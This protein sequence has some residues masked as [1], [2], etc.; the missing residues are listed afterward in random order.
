MT[1]RLYLLIMLI[2]LPLSAMAEE[3][4]ITVSY[5]SS[6]YGLDPAH[7]FTT[8]EAQLFT[9]VYEGLVSYH[10]LTLEPVAAAAERWVV[11]P[12]GKTY[13]FF[14]RP[15][16]HFWNGDPVKATNF[17]E[18]WFRL[19]S[20]DENAEYSFLLDIIEG[21]LDYRTGKTDDRSTVG[22]KA[23]SDYML[24]VKLRE[25]AEYFLKILC[26][27]SFSPVHPLNLENGK[28]KSGPSALG[29]GPFYI[30]KADKSQITLKK[31]I[32]YW[33][34]NNIET[35]K[36]NIVFINDPQLAA[37]RF[38]NGEIQWAP[39][40]V[41]L[42]MVEDSDKLVSNPLF[43]TSYFFFNTSNEALKNGDVRRALALIL[44]WNEIRNSNN[45]F[46]PTATL[47]PAIPGYPAVEGIDKRDFKDALQLLH[48]AGYT[49]GSGIGNIVIRVPNG[50][51]PSYI[52]QI[53]KETWEKYL[54][55]T[56]QIEV[57]PYPDYYSA[58]KLNDYSLGTTTWIGD[59]ADPL[60][61]LQ[62]WTSNS[63]LNDSN[64]AD[65]D[66]DGLIARAETEAPAQRYKTLAEAESILLET[67]LVLPLENYP[68]FNLVDLDSL[69]G[70]Y[71]NVL[72]IH[73]FRYFRLKEPQM[74]EGVVD[75]TKSKDAVR[76]VSF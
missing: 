68:A 14:L 2:I 23:I 41:Y 22:I 27:H 8:T 19:L 18:A 6:E 7:A 44:P 70:W 61:F 50:N 11:S 49:K 17:S 74:P 30:T 56:V 24:E 5:A 29:N 39:D 66:Y 1:R 20:P 64:F 75:S 21:A 13:T 72:D 52:G 31:N 51:L 65:P 62:M 10:P 71:P 38:N 60:T 37:E 63:N 58:L 47:I 43:A 45:Y 59:F 53:M 55:V 35:D 26:H 48:S 12:D 69:E 15:E 33:D 4:G 54:D 34:Q 57:R 16:G 28:W 42:S 67:A 3:T 76:F 25:P 9:A 73:P 46:L 32:L 36:I 40:G